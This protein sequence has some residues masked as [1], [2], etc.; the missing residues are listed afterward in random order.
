MNYWLI[1]LDDA[2]GIGP[3]GGNRVKIGAFTAP[4]VFRYNKQGEAEAKVMELVTRFPWMKG[5]LRAAHHCFFAD[6]NQDSDASLTTPQPTC[7]G[8]KGPF[9]EFGG[10]DRM[11]GLSD[12]ETSPEVRT[13]LVELRNLLWRWNRWFPQGMVDELRTVEQKHLTLITQLPA[14][15]EKL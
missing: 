3:G 2:V 1:E 4:T 12:K 11:F 14:P 13:M 7:T 10:F 15:W 9:K 5:R 8:Q 6:A